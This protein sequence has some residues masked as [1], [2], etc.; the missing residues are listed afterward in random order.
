[1]KRHGWIFAG[2]AALAL[3]AACGGGDDGTDPGATTP[4]VGASNINKYEGDWSRCV[5]AAPGSKKETVV[6]TKYNETTVVF[7]ALEF[8]YAS[9]DCTG[10]GNFASSTGTIVFNGSKTIAGA[11]VDKAI[12]NTEGAASEKQVYLIQG[13][14]TGP[15][16]LTSGRIGAGVDTDGYPTTLD[17]SSFTKGGAAL[18]KYLGTWRSGCV[19]ASHGSHEEILTL[20]KISDTSAEFTWAWPSY[21]STNC[22]G[23]SFGV[24]EQGGFLLEGTKNIG[25]DTVDKVILSFDAPR[26]EEKLVFLVKGTGPVKLTY[27]RIGG[28]ADAEGY[29]TTLTGN[30]LTRQ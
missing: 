2:I 10:G 21:S 16:T 13:T 17:S 7:L 26:P 19:A 6:L 27:G 5:P 4:V 29:P 14:G 15:F 28:G 24:A 23:I 11:T 8:T 22:S 3:M 25:A 20:T 1:M 18:E 12:V 30:V 9:S